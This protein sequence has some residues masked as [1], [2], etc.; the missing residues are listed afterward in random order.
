MLFDN[1]QQPS[2]E[3]SI[4]ENSMGDFYSFFSYS[5]KLQSL[6]IFN[7]CFQVDCYS[8]FFKFL[9]TLDVNRYAMIGIP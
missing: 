6:C 9:T 8:Q 3:S 5:S 4:G 2:E 7:E 1:D